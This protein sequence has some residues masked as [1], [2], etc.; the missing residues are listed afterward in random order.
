MKQYIYRNMGRGY[1]VSAKSEDIPVGSVSG[2]SKSLQPF[3][4]RAMIASGLKVYKQ[5][6]TDDGNLALICSYLDPRG[7]RGSY[8]AHVLFTDGLQERAR[9]YAMLPAGSGYFDSCYDADRTYTKEM[10]EEVELEDF[11]KGRSIS[12]EERL[13]YIRQE[14]GNDEMLRNMLC[15]LLDVSALNPRMIVVQLKDDDLV[16]LSRHGRMLAEALLSVMPT[17]VASN[18]GWL[19][20]A[21]D[22]GDNAAY[23]LRF[24]N[25]TTAGFQ[26]NDNGMAY[27]FDLSGD[28][29]TLR[30]AKGAENISDEF[31]DALMEGF[32]S[33]DIEA[34]KSLCEAVDDPE[35][36][37]SV[38][39]T[40]LQKRLMLCYKL[41]V[42]GFADN[43]DMYDVLEWHHGMVLDFLNKGK[44]F[45]SMRS[46]EVC[47]R[48]VLDHILPEL[49]ENGKSWSSQ[50]VKCVGEIFDDAEKLFKK[51]SP[52][53][54]EYADFIM[55]RVE[56]DTLC[57][58][59]PD[60]L[61]KRMTEYFVQVFQK[62]AAGASGLYGK[63]VEKWV[64]EHWLQGA[65]EKSRTDKVTMQQVR[66]VFNVVDAIF[67]HMP[68]NKEV[69]VALFAKFCMTHRIATISPKASPFYTETT[70][71][72]LENDEAFFS[73]QMEADLKNELTNEKTRFDRQA[74][75][76]GFGAFRQYR[77]WIQ[78]RP[79]LEEKYTEYLRK[80]LDNSIKSA[81]VF[82]LIEWDEKNAASSL[83]SSIQKN[84]PELQEEAYQTVHKY[85]TTKCGEALRNI[86]SYYPANAKSMQRIVE[87]AQKNGIS[88][89]KDVYEILDWAANTKF[90]TIRTAA[91]E[92][93]EEHYAKIRGRDKAL[94]DKVMSIIRDKV[95]KRIQEL[96][97]D[98]T[99]EDVLSMVSALIIYS[100]VF[101]GKGRMC[102]A[103]HTL[104]EKFDTFEKKKGILKQISKKN[105]ALSKED[106]DDDSARKLH[107]WSC[108][109]EGYL[110]RYVR[111]DEKPQRFYPLSIVV[112]TMSTRN[113]RRKRIPPIVPL[114]LF[115]A[116]VLTMIVSAIL[117]RV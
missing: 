86:L 72:I 84:A 104:A 9:Y 96:A 49:W 59:K 39:R 36:K 48:Y 12:A 1:F 11:F 112:S 21:N 29:P 18:I 76:A 65:I 25:R 4:G 105:K 2:V 67:S 19:S 93:C 91:I 33:N 77:P 90:L 23:K 108:R 73:Q 98:D 78:G 107:G 24:T 22:C 28:A 106:S 35:Y 87:F 83:Y 102:I 81:D 97:S 62:D 42:S 115:A 75:P 50:A 99:S 100:L 26:L 85:A 88:Y 58:W 70:K 60:E 32:S 74:D 89:T 54:A 3:H 101:D 109:V 16:E 116:S 79:G 68:D 37:D 113:A 5:I 110:K 61:C 63:A 117:M 31:V 34:V 38:V 51:G 7:D 71:Y 13:A 95:S 46:W 64:R 10:S 52:Y 40:R 53:A 14:L 20:I 47:N 94:Q 41:R 80:V 8:L 44:P 17:Q 15:A 103:L 111:S 55:Q 43:Q 66:S 30:P 114:V 92:D 56:D 57:T 82:Q 45:E 6:Q 27:L 69:Y